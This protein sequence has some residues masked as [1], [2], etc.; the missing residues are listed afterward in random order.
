MELRIRDI[1]SAPIVGNIDQGYI[2]CGG[3]SDLYNG[4]NVCGVIITPRCDIAQNKT[5]EVYYLPVVGLCDWKIIEFPNIFCTRLQ[6]ETIS[7]LEDK[8]TK[9][10]I[11]PSIISKFTVDEIND[12]LKD[13]GIATKDLKAIHVKLETL[14]KISKYHETY[15]LEIFNSLLEENP[16]PRK[17]IIKELLSNK[18]PNYYVLDAK[19]AHYVVRLRE[20][21]RLQI[22]LFRRIGDGIFFND[23]SAEDFKCND[24]TINNPDE[25]MI[26]SLYVLKSPYVEHLMQCFIQW[27]SRIG[28]EDIDNNTCEYMIKNW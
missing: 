5:N 28:V 27:F 15:D 12:I 3:K 20:L 7:S 18:L 17:T 11:S 6:N 14:N 10:N 21:K 16:G 22:P 24:I 9:L 8:L 25:D 4:K 1:F 19:E 26:Y 2:F 13:I 23:L